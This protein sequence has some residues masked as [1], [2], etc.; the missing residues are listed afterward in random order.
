MDDRMSEDER[1]G[2]MNETAGSRDAQR[3]L[4]RMPVPQVM[5]RKSM[6]PKFKQA[7]KGRSE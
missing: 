2:G 3:N 5:G 4:E 1:K 7:R 6:K